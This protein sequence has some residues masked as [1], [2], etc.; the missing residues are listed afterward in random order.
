MLGMAYI[1]IAEKKYAEAFLWLEK[2]V[3]NKATLEQLM[4]DNECKKIMDMPEWDKLLKKY[5]TDKVKD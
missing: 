2:A 4:N 1:A 3:I 5:F